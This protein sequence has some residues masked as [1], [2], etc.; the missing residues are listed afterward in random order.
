[1]ALCVKL[2][3]LVNI[4]VKTLY[5][6]NATA[7]NEFIPEGIALVPLIEEHNGSYQ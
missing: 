7:L 4:G 3:S 5:Q 2:G 6:I 1:M